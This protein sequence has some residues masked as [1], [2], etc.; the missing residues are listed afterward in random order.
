MQMRIKM[1]RPAAVGRLTQAEPDV[2]AD[3]GLE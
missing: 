1:Q 2:L 3:S